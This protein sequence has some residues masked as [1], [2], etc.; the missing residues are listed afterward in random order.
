MIAS[1]MVGISRTIKA[2]RRA[3]FAADDRHDYAEAARIGGSL[4]DA[5]DV[6][7]A[8]PVETPADVSL[9]LG[10]AR[11][12]M[13]ADGTSRSLVRRLTRVGGAIARGEHTVRHI[14]ELRACAADLALVCDCGCAEQA[15]ARI[16][17]VI[18]WLARPRLVPPRASGTHHASV[19]RR[20]T[21]DTGRR[22]K[23]TV[24]R[25]TR[26]ARQF[27]WR[28]RPACDACAAGPGCS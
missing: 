10:W 11:H 16:M 28:R 27:S 25:R 9:K 21:R 3:H 24:G 22:R 26:L 5:E 8:L 17:A 15:T 2:L 23:R 18:D 6:E 20:G 19:R 1:R 7:R 14:I 4:S 12:W 13:A